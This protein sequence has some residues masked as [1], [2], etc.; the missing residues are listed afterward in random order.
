MKFKNLSLE[1][2]LKNFS[3][4]WAKDKDLEVI[5]KEYARLI[6]TDEKKCVDRALA[7]SQKHKDKKNIKKRLK[8][9]KVVD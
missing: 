6:N 7:Y 1:D 3:K 9:K 4:L 8:G 2:R 5:I